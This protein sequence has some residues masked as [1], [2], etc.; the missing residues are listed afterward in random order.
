MIPQRKENK[1]KLTEAARKGIGILEN[2]LKAEKEKIKENYN[3][4]KH[5]KAENEMK[6]EQYTKDIA[7]TDERLTGLGEMLESLD[8]LCM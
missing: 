8:A 6:L 4:Y 2:D 3:H 1:K 5:K 7:S